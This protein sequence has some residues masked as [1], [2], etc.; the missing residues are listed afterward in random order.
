MRWDAAVMLVGFV[1]DGALLALLLWRRILR[2]LPVFVAYIA[3]SLFSALANLLIL[4]STRGYVVLWSVTTVLD[5]LFYLSVLFELKKYVVRYN[6][7]TP[8]PEGLVFLLL[9]IVSVPMWL[10]A[11]WPISDEFTLAW[12]LS[13]RT[14]QLT[15]ILELAGILTLAWLTNRQN[16]RWPEREF[17]VVM[18][19]GAWAMIQFSVLIVHEH[20]FIGATY[21]WL[22]LLTP[23]AAAIATVY[24]V[25]YF[26]IDPSSGSDYRGGPAEKTMPQKQTTGAKE[27][28]AA[29]FSTAEKL[30][31]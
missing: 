1:L 20:G 24:W 21:H 23:I 13:L 19:M 15:S 11:Q 9:V 27:S 31:R 4:H 30:G 18:G 12:R 17:R 22:D 14:L 28:F 6:R 8:L 10:L 16:L 29:K 5:T 3:Y 25:H 2:V 7:A 26:W